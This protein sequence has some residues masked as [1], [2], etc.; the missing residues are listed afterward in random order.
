MKPDLKKALEKIIVYSYDEE[1]KHFESCTPEEKQNHIFNSL[2]VIR[3]A[4]Q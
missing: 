1:K 2:E 4:L 3:K